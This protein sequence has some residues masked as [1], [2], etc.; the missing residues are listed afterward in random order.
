MANSDL[1]DRGICR[2]YQD[3]CAVNSFIHNI[4]IQGVV[5]IAF[6]DTNF[7]SDDII[8]A[9]HE[10]ASFMVQYPHISPLSSVNPIIRSSPMS[11]DHSRCHSHRD[12]ILIKKQY[13]K[14]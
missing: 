5:R 12:G 3:L 13:D 4:L 6:E 7:V 9:E 1:G 8:T 14:I 10:F 11:K 2:L